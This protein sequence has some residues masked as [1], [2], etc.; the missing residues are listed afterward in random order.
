MMWASVHGAPVRQ[1]DPRAYPGKGAAPARATLRIAKQF[2]GAKMQRVIILVAMMLVWPAAA[3][4]QSCPAI[5]H[6]FTGVAGYFAH[7][8]GGDM[9][10]DVIQQPYTRLQSEYVKFVQTRCNPHPLKFSIR[11]PDRPMPNTANCVPRSASL[12][13]SWAAAEL[14]NACLVAGQSVMTRRP[15]QPND[16]YASSR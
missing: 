11:A 3:S 9:S 14:A 10:I 13:G 1:N 12:S 2:G 7:A 6:F 15:M 5:L 16:A 8:F 4:A